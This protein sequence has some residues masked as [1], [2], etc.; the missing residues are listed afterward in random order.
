MFGVHFEGHPDMKRILMPDDW[1][2]HP[3]QRDYPLTEEV[4]QFKYGVK[5]K[6]PSQII[7]YVQCN[8]KNQ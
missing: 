6:I 3:L 5:P 1:I 8:Q 4:V 7:P 2:G